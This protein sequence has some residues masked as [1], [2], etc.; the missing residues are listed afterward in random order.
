MTLTRFMLGSITVCVV[1]LGLTGCG[2]VLPSS[3]EDDCSEDAACAPRA[4]QPIPDVVGLNLE[5]ACK[6]MSQAGYVGGV[7]RIYERADERAE[8]VLHQASE[9]GSFGALGQVIMLEVAG[10][11]SP[12]D[13]PRGCVIRVPGRF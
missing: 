10:P 4:E 9:P 8:T 13:L 1:L 11:V 12:D 6:E 5:D 7:E 3:G 2:L